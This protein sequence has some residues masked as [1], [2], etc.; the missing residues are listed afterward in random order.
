MEAYPALEGLPR[1]EQLRCR[2]G[3]CGVVFKNFKYLFRHLKTK[4]KVSVG[5]LRGHWVHTAMLHERKGTDGISFDEL[6]YVDLAY[7]YTTGEIHESRFVCKE[8]G[9]ELTKARCVR[10]MKTAH[11]LLESDTK[12]WLTNKDATLLKT[13]A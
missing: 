4:H 9:K 13:G 6:L 5:E 1:A 12:K 3:D 11:G 2:L 8:C 10:H 7:H